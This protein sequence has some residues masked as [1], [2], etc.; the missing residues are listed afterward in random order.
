MANV[1]VEPERIDVRH[2]QLR[3]IGD[4]PLIVHA[5]ST[6]AKQMMLDKQ[7]K[8]GKQAQVA[9]DPEQD[10]QDSL[11]HLPDGTGYGFP[12]VGIK[13]CAIR[14]AKGL[15]MV[16]TDSRAA[17]HIEGDLAPI[18]GEPSMREDMVRIGQGTAD[19][20]YRGE[21]KEWSIVFS[22]TYNAR[23]LSA[24]QIVTMLDAG[25]FGTGIGEW[26]PEKSGQYGRF[27]VGAV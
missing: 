11:Y 1:Q 2:I 26:R 20:R 21:F 10:Y 12:S 13:S 22:L 9:K 25:G 17:F 16:M 6:K 3:I 14:G 8:R 4:S 15:G 27:H 23:V 24:E 19:V 7:M 5:W 18:T